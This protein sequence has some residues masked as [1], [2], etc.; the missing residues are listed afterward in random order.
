MRVPRRANLE[1]LPMILPLCAAFTIMLIAVTVQH[2]FAG[3]A[4][5]GCC[6]LRALHLPQPRSPIDPAGNVVLTAESYAGRVNYTAASEVAV[7]AV[8]TA[9]IVG[10]IV[11]TISI[12]S[13]RAATQATFVVIA[14]ALGSI[15]AI[16]VI[17]Q[18]ISPALF[19][20]A[21]MTIA[22]ECGRIELLQ[23]WFE[24]AIAIAATLLVAAAGLLLLPLAKEPEKRVEETISNHG[25]L[26]YLLACGT[27]LLVSG[28][29]LKLSLG[30]W[31]ETYFLTTGNKASVRILVDSIVGSWGVYYSMFL[32]CTYIPAAAVLR[33]RLR[34][35][36]STTTLP[37][38]PWQDAQWS[39]TAIAQ[40]LGRVTAIL[41][42]LLLS[43]APEILRF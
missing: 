10:F 32:A 6:G 13:G 42:P 39:A 15:A 25:R 7:V 16:T 23:V 2:A 8:A 20:I 31:A 17:T 33:T 28:V 37:A 4:V 40:D 11:A 3:E 22:R 34:R 19:R 9:L 12:R 26:S 14:L 18:D 27:I 41:A 38:G 21:D 30:R 1:L 35:L 24:R 5:T 43:Q 29:V 36:A